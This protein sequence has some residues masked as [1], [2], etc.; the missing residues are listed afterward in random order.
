V[1][2]KPG[3]GFFTLTPEDFDPQKELEEGK[4]RIKNPCLD[5]QKE[6]EKG[7]V[8][9]LFEPQEAAGAGRGHVSED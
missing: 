3:G 4:V 2:Q 8:R 6:L 7:K 9:R 5:P 1:C